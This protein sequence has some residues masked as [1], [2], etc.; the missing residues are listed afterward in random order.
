MTVQFDGIAIGNMTSFSGSAW[1][2]FSMNDAGAQE[3]VFETG[4]IS[5]E[6]ASGG[7]RVNV[8]PRQGGNSFNGSCLAILRPGQCR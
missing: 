6:A 7:V 3:M 8:I 4:A 2:N 5:T 1:A